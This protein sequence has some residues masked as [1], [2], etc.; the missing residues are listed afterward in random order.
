MKKASK[1][2]DDDLRPEYDFSSLKGGVRGKYYR[3]FQ[4]GTNIVRL[5]PDLAKVFPTDEAVNEALRTVVRASQAPRRSTRQFIQA[6]AA[7]R[8]GLIQA[9]GRPDCRSA[10]GGGAR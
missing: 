10:G 5:E 2:Q 3:R 7:S 4:A 8:R 6:D 1:K 9:L